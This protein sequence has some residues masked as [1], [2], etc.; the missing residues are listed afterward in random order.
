MSEKINFDVHPICAKYSCGEASTSK[1]PTDEQPSEADVDC[2]VDVTSPIAQNTDTMETTT[3][4]ECQTSKINATAKAVLTFLG[5]S[6]LWGLFFIAYC[7]KG[8]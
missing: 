2:H 8:K 7:R 4:I 1:P 5:A 3:K 6:F